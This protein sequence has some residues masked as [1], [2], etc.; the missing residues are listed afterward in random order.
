MT[1]AWLWAARWLFHV[2]VG[3]G[4]LLLIAW[5]VVRWVRQPARQQRVAEWGAGASLVL[6]GLCIA[7]AWLVVPLPGKPPWVLSEPEPPRPPSGC[8]SKPRAPAPEPPPPPAK[9]P[10]EGDPLPAQGEEF[11]LMPPG[12]EAPAPPRPAPPPPADQTPPVEAEAGAAFDLG[13]VAPLL[14]GAYLAGAAWFLGRLGWGYWCL[15]RCLRRAVEAPEAV[16]QVYESMSPAGP[17]PRLLVSPQARVPLSCGLL[18]PTIVLPASLCAPEA[19]PRLRWALAH[20]RAH[21]LRRDAASCLLFGLAHAVYYFVPWLWRL[22]GQ[23]RLCREYVADAAAV[24]EAGP[25]EDYAEFLLGWSAAP[26][27]PQG[28]TGV[29]GH[30]SDLFRRVTMLIK[31]PLKVEEHCPRRWSLLAAAGLLSLAVVGAG[32]GLRAAVPAEDRKEE[33]RKVRD[34]TKEKDKVKDKVKDKDADEDRPARQRLRDGFPDLDDLM[35]RLP[36]ELS[37]EQVKKI[38]QQLEEARKAL[39]EAQKQFPRGGFQPFQQF[40][41]F[42]DNFPFNRGGF[43]VGFG[44]GAQPRLGAR[45]E[46]PSPALVDQLDLPRDQGL[47]IEDVVDN[48]A[49]EKAGLK[50]HDILL[51]LGGKPVPSDARAFAQLVRDLKADAKLDVTVMRKGR[52]ETVKGLMLPKAKDAASPSPFKFKVPA[53]DFDFGGAGLGGMT[54]VTRNNDDF[55]ARHQKDGVTIEV[56]GKVTGGKAEVDAVKVKDGGK[57]S[58]FKGVDKVPQEHREKVRELVRMVEGGKVRFQLEVP[59]K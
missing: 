16:R 34:V 44:R 9:P 36:A 6:A 37:D 51:E 45:V 28:A 3:G 29:A 12:D 58:S 23:A 47:V 17:R 35:K 54:S 20:E 8:S 14:V 27:L 1:E 5:V 7:P 19:A 18:R 4:L 49:A 33:D 13:S 25:V 56:S 32:V 26:A 31:S 30:S 10:A 38:R 42:P 57:T 52:K 39:E 24:A 50:K 48:S 11:I 53:F 2:A 40:P 21:L 43:G 41:P 55:T 59:R 46:K 15:A 22:R